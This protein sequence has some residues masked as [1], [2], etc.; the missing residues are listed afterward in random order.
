MPKFKLCSFNLS[1]KM[2]CSYTS[3]VARLLLKIN[4]GLL[5]TDSCRNWLG[6]QIAENVFLF[7]SIV[8]Y[9]IIEVK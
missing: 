3:I 1:V 9:C 4:L 5:G 8:L 2:S 7:H 6:C